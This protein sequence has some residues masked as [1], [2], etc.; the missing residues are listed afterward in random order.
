MS[1]KPTIKKITQNEVKD[2]QGDECIYYLSYSD[3]MT[4]IMLSVHAGRSITP[5]E[6]I[7][8]LVAFVNDVEMNPESLFVEDVDVESDLSK[9]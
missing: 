1:K 7:Q 4:Q 8:S 6:Y 9:H 3:D 2:P 5:E